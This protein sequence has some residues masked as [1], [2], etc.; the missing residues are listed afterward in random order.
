MVVEEGPPADSRSRSAY[1]SQECGG[2]TACDRHQRELRGSDERGK[3]CTD[4]VQGE[5]TKLA[6][7]PHQPVNGLLRAMASERMSRGSHRAVRACGGG[8]A[9]RARKDGPKQIG[10]S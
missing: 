1:K 5:E 7:R 6:R 10:P 2:D 8:L 3:E 4:S 9:M